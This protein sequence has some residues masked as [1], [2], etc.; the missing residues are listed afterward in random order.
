M[1][2]PLSLAMCLLG[3]RA[4]GYARCRYAWIFGRSCR[5]ELWKSGAEACEKKGIE[6]SGGGQFMREGIM[7]S[8]RPRFCIRWNAGISLQSNP[9]QKFHLAWET[10]T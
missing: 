8:R 3:N 1:S 2:F 5:G 9:S 7:R 6:L 10:L 4:G